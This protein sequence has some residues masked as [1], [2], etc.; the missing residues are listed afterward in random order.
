M[1]K[2]NNHLP[3][4]SGYWWRLYYLFASLITLAIS[5]YCLSDGSWSLK[6]QYFYG[7]VYWDMWL[8]LSHGDLTADCHIIHDE[9]HVIDGKT[10]AYFLPLPALIRGLFSLIGL[11]QYAI[12]SFL[13]AVALFL[14]SLNLYFYFIRS[15][16]IKTKEMKWLT[17]FLGGLLAICSPILI[18]LTYPMMFWEAI[19]W[20]TALFMTCSLHSYRLLISPKNL[21]TVF[22]FSLLCGA[23]LF[24]RPTIFVAS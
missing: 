9:T 11:G 19:V 12:P 2:E 5:L 8:R 17:S 24:T 18:L 22:L 6:S 1:T 3:H 23:A 21:K 13:T 10:Y 4:D 7:D 14:S 20:G 15:A 16:N